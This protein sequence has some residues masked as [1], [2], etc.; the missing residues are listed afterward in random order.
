[1]PLPAVGRGEEGGGW[2]GRRGPL[3]SRI[4]DALLLRPPSGG[5][6]RGSP[7][8]PA[9]KDDP[10]PNS[11]STTQTGTTSSSR[12]SHGRRHAR[13]GRTLARRAG[14]A[15]AAARREAAETKAG[16]PAAHGQK[17]TAE[18]ALPPKAAAKWVPPP[19][20]RAHST[21]DAAVG[22]HHPT[23]GNASMR[24]VNSVLAVAAG[25]QWGAGAMKYSPS[26]NSSSHTSSCSTTAVA[27]P[28]VT[29]A[30]RARVVVATHLPT[31]PRAAPPS[32]GSTARRRRRRATRGARSARPRRPSS[33]EARTSAPRPRPRRRGQ[34]LRA[35]REATRFPT[36][37][38]GWRPRP[39]ALRG[40]AA[41]LSRAAGDAPT[42]ESTTRG[43]VK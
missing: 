43:A 19:A 33:A 29:A 23:V 5:G 16:T 15:D 2:K 4:A 27:A 17:H 28:V 21:V 39:M 37:R 40:E 25:R 20:R 3:R 8:P 10:P 42:P 26:A 12:L 32:P 9:L 36:V 41:E 6:R 18:P 24:C 35:E 31:P 7:G 34:C 13:G 14:E 1:M 38:A 11:V 22:T 30:P